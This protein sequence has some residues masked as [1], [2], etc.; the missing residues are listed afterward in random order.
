MDTGTKHPDTKAT[1][2]SSKNLKISEIDLPSKPSETNMSQSGPTEGSPS[3][4]TSCVSIGDV[5]T[6]SI[7]ESE[8]D[9]APM[10]DQGMYYYGYYPGFSGSPREWDE[11]SYFM[12]ANQLEIQPSAF[13]SDNG[14]MLYYLPGY[15]PGYMPYNQI[16]PGAVISVDGQY[17]AQPSYYPNAVF[18]QPLASPGFVPQSVAYGSELIPAYPWDSSL[19]FTNGFQE[20]GSV[21]VVSTTSTKSKFS[22]RG[23]T[24]AS[25]KTSSSSR[26][27]TSETK[28]AS[29][30]LDVPPTPAIPREPLKPVS[31]G[32]SPVFSKAYL[33]I[34]KIPSYTSQGKGGIL[35]PNSHNTVKGYGKNWV[36]VE[37]VKV[38]NNHQGFGDSNLQNEQ[39]CGPRISNT[40]TSSNSAIDFVG[41]LDAVKT[42]TFSIPV[43]TVRK[44]M[45]NLS[46]FTTKY[47]QGLFYVIKSYSEDD[48]H[49]SIK[50]N[51]WA[52]TP[53]GNKRLDNAFQ[54]AQEKMVEKG[55]KC[56][57]FLFFSV[58]ASGQF[59]GVAEMLD[60]VDFNKSMDFWQQDKWNGFF[61]V[62]WHII[63]DIPN[64]QF[65]HIILE[66][67]ENKPVTNSRDTQEVKFLQ[68]TEMLNIFKNYS[69]KTSILD[70]FDFYENRQKTMHYK[71]SKPLAPNLDH[72]L[73]KTDESV[74]GIKPGDLKSIVASLQSVELEAG[75]P[76]EGLSAVV[77]AKE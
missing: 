73:P 70:D 3:D 18:E 49:K 10:A 21:G 14:S 72:L 38:R 41:S 32:L 55:S 27:S 53:N 75:K 77:A 36:G 26:S 19:L 67:N 52:S 65:R 22:S 4:A 58:N 69:S 74:Q 64:P 47:D 35:H 68:G 71:R 63:K 23:H 48:V 76:K 43:A 45:Y 66:N 39:Y 60:R 37:K 25:S 13:Q 62:K 31:K 28:G 7:K 44:D 5:T 9:Q 6:C 16:L 54:I 17:L 42:D 29:P 11:Q 15:Q 56:P 20:N 2:D 12:A 33:P 51:V 46:D 8:A 61:P 50:Y 59:C 57:V 30:A 40:K 34:S 24:L 1:E